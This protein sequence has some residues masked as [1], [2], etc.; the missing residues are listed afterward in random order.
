MLKQ[1]KRTWHNLEEQNAWREKKIHS[2][3]RFEPQTDKYIF[4]LNWLVWLIH[5]HASLPNWNNI[6]LIQSL[7][8]R[9][10]RRCQTL[11]SEN[12]VRA[13]SKTFGRNVFLS[14]LLLDAPKCFSSKLQNYSLVSSTL[15]LG[16]QRSLFSIMVYGKGGTSQ[17]VKSNFLGTL[18][19]LKSSFLAW[20]HPNSSFLSRARLLMLPGGL[21]GLTLY[22]AALV[23]PRGLPGLV[24]NPAALVVPSG[25][26]V[27]VR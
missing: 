4:C 27:L 15:L 8:M 20:S 25:R 13:I 5:M 1:S 12:S 21:P 3:V 7:I 11:Y 22:P 18:Q 19:L 16:S 26:P 2:P 6:L 24:L 10:R 9:G 14:I 23:V 17:A